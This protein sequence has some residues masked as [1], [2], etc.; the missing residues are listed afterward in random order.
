MTHQQTE[1]AD[2][3][4]RALPDRWMW[5]V[6]LAAVA[7]ALLAIN[8][9]FNFHFFIGYTLLANRYL[10]S[11]L[12]FIIPVIYILIPATARATKTHVPWYDVVGAVLS[13]LVLAYLIANSLRMIENGWEL[14]APP[15]AVYVAILFW[16]LIFEASRR[17]GGNA[18]AVVV[19]VISLYPLY[20]DVMPGPIAGFS[21]PLDVVAGYHAMSNESA[22]GIPL[23]AFGNLVV[24]FIIFGVALQH[25]GAG[26]FFINLAFA[27]LGHVRGGPGKV[28]ILSSGLMGSMSGSVVTNVMTTGVMTIPAMRKVGL[29]AKFS[30]G[31]EACASTGGVLMPPVM[32]TTAFIMANFLGV[33]YANIAIAAA[34]PSMLYFLGLFIQIDARAA[35]EEI[36]GLDHSDLPSLRQTISEGWYYIFAFGLLIFMLIVLKREA[37]APYYATPVLIIINQIAAKKDR[38]GWRDLV[39]FVDTMAK[40]FAELVGVLAGIGL[41]IGALSMT[42]LVGTLVNDLISLAGGSVL[43]LLIMGA[44]T[45]FVLGIGMTVTA[46]YIFLAI[47]LAPAL[48]SVGLDPMAVHMFILY[49]GMLSFI[50]PPVALGAFAA[51]T[52]AKADPMKTGFEAMRLGSIIYFI[53]FFF[54]FDPA[55]ILNGTAWDT[56]TAFGFVVLAIFV[57]TGGLQ[58]YVVGI[59][60]ILKGHVLELPARILL[61]AGCIPIGMPGG[62]ILGINK[63]SMLAAGAVLILPVLLAA[64]IHNRGVNKKSV[65]LA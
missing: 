41:I 9:A 40:L 16:V 33:P 45:S 62:G 44:A 56:L 28:A 59:G 3:R 60:N 37:L 15:Q 13:F 32:G 54:V 34:I 4:F 6:R 57:G 38:W 55:L 26:R 35:R 39:A 43:M 63:F 2:S 51:A 64:A 29:S 48:T 12:L 20:A 18:L 10:Y 25:T 17:A 58:G 24:G 53:P 31:V 30:A 1:A 22:M 11:I 21:S 5:P 61:V 19:G 36:R 50:T 49:W 52:I 27:L 47:L 14:A 7:V 65:H 8:Q 46:A 23:R 42:G